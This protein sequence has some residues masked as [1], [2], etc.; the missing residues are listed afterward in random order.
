[1]CIRDS[2]NITPIQK[3]ST[4]TFTI[5]R[6]SQTLTIPSNV[7]AVKLWMIGGGGAGFTATNTGDGSTFW[8]PGITAK[9]Y[10]GILNIAD[11]TTNNQLTITIGDSG[12]VNT[13]STSPPSTPGQS[14]TIVG[15]EKTLVAPGGGT[16]GYGTGGSNVNYWHYPNNDVASSELTEIYDGQPAF[17]GTYG[18]G[19]TSSTI[20]KDKGAVILWYAHSG[21]SSSSSSGGGNIT[22]RTERILIAGSG[23]Y[24]FHPNLVY[25]K[26][27]MLGGGGSGGGST[28]TTSG[29]GSPKGGPGGNGAVGYRIYTAAEAGTSASYT[30]GAGGVNNTSN[31]GNPGGDST[32]TVNGTASATVLTAGGGAGGGQGGTNVGTTGANGTTINSLFDFNENGFGASNGTGGAG[33]RTSGGTGTPGAMYIEEYYST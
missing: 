6:D 18:Q 28:N 16:Y 10:Q 20:T 32:F 2:S 3:L 8:M 1:M 4:E 9:T 12:T 33:G 19:A 5:I 21:S 29:T 30:V 22:F 7:A 23:T 25:V 24:A 27:Y 13:T 14:T 31:A 15:T 17:W 11:L 26:V